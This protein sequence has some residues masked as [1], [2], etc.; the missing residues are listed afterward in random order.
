MKVSYDYY[1]KGY[2]T[3]YSIYLPEKE[4]ASVEKRI[5]EQLRHK[6]GSSITDKGFKALQERGR[7][8]AWYQR[9]IVALEKSID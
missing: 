2:D 8:V 4:I 9:R 3:Y 7:S 6:D 1:R 5:S